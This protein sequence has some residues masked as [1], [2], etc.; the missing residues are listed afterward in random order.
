[1][2]GNKKGV[3]SFV[4]KDPVD[5]DKIR[6]VVK[7]ANDNKWPWLGDDCT[8]WDQNPTGRNRRSDPTAAPKRSITGQDPPA[9]RYSVR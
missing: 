4:M 8:G 7:G 2:T 1:M 3:I 6:I 5:T 9:G